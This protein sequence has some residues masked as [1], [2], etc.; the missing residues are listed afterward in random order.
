MKHAKYL[1]LLILNIVCIFHY[2]LQG[3]G[4]SADTW[5]RI[6]D[7]S[8]VHLRK[9]RDGLEGWREIKQLYDYSIN[10]INAKA[11][12]PQTF[13]ISYRLI[14]MVGISRTNCYFRISLGEKLQHELEC[15]PSQ[16]FYVVGQKRWLPACQLQIGDQLFRDDD[17]K[18]G[19]SIAV[20]KLEF[21]KRPCLVYLLEVDQ[22]H[23]FLV[24]DKSVLTHNMPLAAGWV[25]NIAMAFGEGAVAGGSA[26]SYFGPITCGASLLLGGLV[27]VGIAYWSG[28][29]KVDYKLEFNVDQL[30]QYIK[31]QERAGN[32]AKAKKQITPQSSG[33]GDKEP[34]DDEDDER[35]LSSYENV[36]EP[37]ASTPNIETDVTKKQFKKNLESDGWDK[38]TSKDGKCD[39]FTKD[40]A[41][42]VIRDN[43]KSTNGPTVDYYKPGSNSISIKIRLNGD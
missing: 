33:S 14:K 30:D 3:H 17:D 42:Y 39:I 21:I 32:Q 8:D 15:T 18:Q 38:I 16:S 12:H 5:I 25:F 24:G 29:S 41:K 4:F 26:G 40:G 1:I 31:C 27:G 36:T 7:R 19:N 13:L 34:K 2:Q 37:G 11:Y 20:T 22:Y 23:T 6:R 35:K 10:R 9:H 43:A 28:G